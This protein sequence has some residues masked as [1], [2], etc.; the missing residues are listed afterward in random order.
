MSKP[1]TRATVVHGD[2]EAESMSASE[3]SCRSVPVSFFTFNACRD[4][5]AYYT[6]RRKFIAKGAKDARSTSSSTPNHA[7][8]FLLIGLSTTVDM[9]F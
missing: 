1:T 4:I 9:G 8:S 2:R 3:I 5:K 7:T 6:G